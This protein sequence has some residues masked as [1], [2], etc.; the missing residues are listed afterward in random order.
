[1]ARDI[2][3]EPYVQQIA[4]GSP[5]RI[6]IAPLTRAAMLV[7]GPALLIGV[8][9]WPLLFT[10][11]VFNDDWF[12]HL[13]YMWH[14][15]LAIR[16]NHLPSL[17]LNYSHAVFY[18]FYASYGG[19]I[20]A[21]TGTFS[22]L[23][24]NAPLTAYVITYLLAFAAA[25]GGWY[26]MA[27]MAGLGRW[28]AHAPGVV[29]IT[30][31]YYL[32][33]IYGRGDWPELVGISM[34][35][36]M[37]AAGLSVLRA[38][39]L[40]MW[41]GAAL[42]GSAI[43][44]FGSH[45][46]T[47]LLGSTVLVVMGLAVAACVPSARREITL[48]GVVRVAGLVVPALLVNA[49][50]LWPAI[51]YKSQTLIGGSYLDARAL[52]TGEMPLVSAG[53]LFTLSRA[54]ASSGAAFALSLPVLEI[55]WVLVSIAIFLGAGRRGAWLR[56]LLVVSCVTALIGVAMTHAGLLLA[57]PRLYTDMQFTYRL[58]SY[59]LLGVSGAVLLVL[60]VGR[61][62]TRGVR[63]WLWTLVPILIVSVVG[64]IQQT[65]AYPP[66]NV[67]GSAF[68]SYLH[69]PLH[70]NV[71]VD[72]LDI[73]QP[74]IAGHRRGLA[75]IDFPPNAVHDDRIS[76]LVHLPPGQ[77]AYTNIGGGPNLV[78]VT[79]ARILGIDPEGND[80]L[81]VARSGAGGS[82]STPA[83]RAPALATERISVSTAAS[84]PVVLGRLLSLGAV[85]VLILEFTVLALRRR[86]VRRSRAGRT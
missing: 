1:M 80:V 20:Y 25:Y 10:D 15:S 56:A 11:S 13:W 48:S 28:Q 83:H 82:Q 84:S 41:P 81:E 49:W 61:S 31:A 19:T 2:R 36:L 66:A 7:G 42:A 29:F 45:N 65:D 3:D 79:G 35:P 24:G 67:R 73:D 44:F 43:V 17:F 26:W 64:A 74:R 34:I 18:P 9:A 72:Y 23:L 60:A 8:L 51:A 30:S 85:I 16:S 47:I 5:R 78:H 75:E 27:R 39:H 40:R 32:T 14:Q 38:D 63:L 71:L 69:P 59:I 12:N 33:L 86:T 62:G 76:E 53:H 52:L 54:S 58:E 77:L 4:T 46:I 37:T 55:A 68:S 50:F 22:L 57:L 6:A 21:L 70:V